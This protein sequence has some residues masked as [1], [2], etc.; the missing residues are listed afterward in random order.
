MNITYAECPLCGT[1][2]D[3]GGAMLFDAL[4][5]GKYKKVLGFE[6]PE[7]KNK[8]AYLCFNCIDMIDPEFENEPLILDH[9]KRIQEEHKLEIKEKTEKE[10]LQLELVKIRISTGLSQRKFAQQFYINL[11]TLQAWESGARKVD[12]TVLNLIKEI[13]DI[14]KRK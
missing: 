10:K 12:Q 1:L 7:V 5:Y 3:D 14:E 11:R 13:I 9:I 2:H 8:R 6:I 4:T